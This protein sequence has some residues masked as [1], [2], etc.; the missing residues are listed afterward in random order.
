MAAGVLAT[1]NSL[2]VT[3]LTPTS[4]D[5]ADS[6]TATSSSKGVSYASSVFGSGFCACQRRNISSRCA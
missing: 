6:D 3:L 1:A 4:V 2:R 5:C